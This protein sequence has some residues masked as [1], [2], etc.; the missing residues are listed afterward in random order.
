MDTTSKPLLVVLGKPKS[1]DS[2]GALRDVCRDHVAR[3]V[4]AGGCLDYWL[5]GRNSR[6]WAN[7]NR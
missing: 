7:R 6:L 4:R 5:S 2:D 3:G 1:A